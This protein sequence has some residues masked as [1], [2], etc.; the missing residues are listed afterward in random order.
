MSAPCPT[1]KLQ[2]Q[3]ISVCLAPCTKL[4]QHGWFYQQQGCCQHSFWVHSCMQAATPSQICL[5]STRWR[6][7]Q[8]SLITTWHTIL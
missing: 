2:G 8:G 7:Q 5:P 6:Y 1:I 4:V 3:T